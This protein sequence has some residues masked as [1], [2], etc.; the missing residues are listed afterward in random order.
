MTA[1]EFQTALAA[2]LRLCRDAAAL[3]LPIEAM[4]A[5]VDTEREQE[6]ASAGGNAELD[7]LGIVIEA[8]GD[9]AS[10]GARLPA[11][12]TPIRVPTAPDGSAV[13]MPTNVTT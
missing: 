5:H 3:R 7:A 8:V 13:P 1:P 12:P 11:E 4:L 9:V 10:I 2:A 6:G